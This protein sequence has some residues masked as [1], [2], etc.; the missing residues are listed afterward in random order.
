VKVDKEHVE[1]FRALL[2]QFGDMYVND[3]FGC[4]HRAHSSIVGSNHEFRVSGHLLSK[5]I[6]YFNGVLNNPQR[7]LAAIVGG[8]KVGDKM[9][10]L[11]NL[12]NKVDKLLIGGAMANS[13]V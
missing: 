3:A 2:N 4:S 10:L 1:K 12:I 9:L 11:E 7:P 13:F 5:E 8:A 6:L